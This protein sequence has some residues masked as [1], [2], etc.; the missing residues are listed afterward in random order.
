MVPIL[1]RVVTS[2]E[3]REARTSTAMQR[4]RVVLF[5]LRSLTFNSETSRAVVLDTVFEP[6][7]WVIDHF[8]RILGPVS[9][10]PL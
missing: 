8:V 5:S 2:S 9:E 7:F 3:A 1:R 4:L 10:F 6:V